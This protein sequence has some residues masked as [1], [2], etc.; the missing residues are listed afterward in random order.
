MTT[1]QELDSNPL[2]MS[3]GLPRFD[4][5]QPEHVV[6][7]VRHCLAQAEQ[8][9]VEL[10][11]HITPTWSGCFA[12]LEEIDRPFEYAWE[13]VTHLFGVMNSDA[14][15]EAYET[16]L[17]DVVKF[18][19][20]TSQS[21]PLYEACLGIRDGAEWAT[22]NNAQ[23]RIVTKRIQ[24]AELAG[25]GLQGDQ[26][27]RFNAI[28]Q[29]LSQIKTKF[30]NNVLDATKA[31][32]LVLTQSDEVAGL[33]ASALSMAAQSYNS[34][35]PD[36]EVKATTDQGPWRFTLD[37]PSFN[38]FLQHGH[39]RDLRERLYRA[40]ITRASSGEFDNTELINRIL[41]L[42]HEKA[43][44]LGFKS[45][46]ELSLASKMAPNVTAVETMFETLRAASWNV[47]LSEFD[48]LKQLAASQGQ[49]EPLL[50]W[51]AAFWAERLRE[52][53]FDFTDEQ[54]R[55]Y[56]PLERVLA[57]MF[58][59]VEKIFGIRVVAKN[60]VPVWHADVRY[61]EVFNEQQQ[62]IAGFYLDPYCRP[63]TKRPGAWMSTCLS[64][65]R[66]DGSL[67]VP[68]AHLVCNSTPP[69]GDK[70]SLMTFREVETLFHEFGHGLQHM[71]TVIDEADAAGINNVEWDAVELPS[72]FMENWCYHRA[73]LLS[74]A[75]HYQTGETLPNDLFEKLTAA[76]TFRAASMMLRQ[77]T[78]GMTDM[79]L[80]S[81][82]VPP[83]TGQAGDS[84]LDIQRQ[85]A[86]VTSILQPLPEDRMLCTFSHIFA[87][88]YSAGYYSYKWAEVL[89]AD[90]W[91]A[92]EE[93]GLENES[94]LC[95][96]G[97]RFRDTVLA[98][99]GSQ[100][101]M[102]VFRQF[103]GRE[104]DPQ[105]LLKQNGLA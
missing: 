16:V 80:H 101:P 34:A 51:D 19:L 73:T 69:V 12:K 32:E 11:A 62:Q 23:R 79:R 46:A 55:P 59:L 87:G 28:V 67:Q 15:R 44:L 102:E 98:L 72:Q 3:G 83:E 2:L 30:S 22:L 8:Q 38:P 14:L 58:E 100:H 94:A 91:G 99:G 42:R 4:L 76:R 52:Q 17:D 71:L 88:G 68:V 105:A 29:E 47:A 86:Q 1:P 95:A 10:E 13:P 84:V 78:F 36:A 75:K 103:R 25:I 35:R 85:V 89:S 49:T 82:Y 24:S 54:L 104:P 43:S 41:K 77:L 92:F 74:I 26:R 6:P 33:P 63:E 45:F 20:R 21:K 93:A 90:A 37:I 64:R 50:H 7:A 81:G 66:V 56:F 60:D 65:R 96:V 27:E 31:F 61:F 39:R 53:R 18:G 9:L 70:P 48:E 5:I 97:R 57:G 40:F